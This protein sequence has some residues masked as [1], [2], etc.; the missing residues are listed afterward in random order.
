[1]RNSSSRMHRLGLIA[2][3]LLVIC[4]VMLSWPSHS[5]KA[6]FPTNWLTVW[7]LLGRSHT[8][9]T[10]DAIENVNKSLFGV[11]KMTD[12]MQKAS[13]EIIEA[14]VSVD[15]DQITSSKHFDGE[16]L[17]EGQNR[18]VALALNVKSALDNSDTTLAR[19]SLGQ[20]LHTLQDFYSH[21]NW[22][23]LGHTSPNV[24]LGVPGISLNRL[25]EAEATC[26]D[27]LIPCD[28]CSF[29]NLITYGLTSGY[30][31][32]EDRDKPNPL[33]CNHGGPF[34]TLLGAGGGINK[35]SVLCQFS[36]HYY[37]HYQAAS[38]ATSHTERFITNL[39]TLYGVSDEQ[40]RLL[41]GV[42]VTLAFAI[43]TTGSM[44]GVIAS[45]KR[46]AIQI[47]DERL[48]TNQEPTKYVLTPFNDPYVGPTVVTSSASEFKSAI[49][50]LFADGGDDCPEL[51]MQGMLQAI[52]ASD[53]GGDL[54]VFTDADPKDS[55]LTGNVTN[56]AKEKKIKVSSALFG[57]CGFGLN[58]GS[59]QGQST[60]A[61]VSLTN[62]AASYTRVANETGGQVFTLSPS[63]ATKITRL[64]DFVVRANVVDLLSIGDTL[65]G[66]P[67]TYQV[68]INTGVSRV[69]FSISGPSSILIK[70]PD[71]SDVLLTDSDISSVTVSG[72]QIVS[73]LSPVTGYW[74][75]VINGIGPFSVAVTAESDLSLSSFKFVKFGGRPGHEGYFPISGLPLLGEQAIA[76]AIMVGSF[77]SA[78]F[79]LR[80]KAG[81][82]IQ[83]LDLETGNADFTGEYYGALTLPGREFLVYVAGLDITGVPYQ[84]VLPYQFKPQSLK[85]TAPEG[86]QVRA[87][88]TINYTFQVQNL[89]ASGTFRLTAS[90]DRSFLQGITPSSVKLDTNQS[91]D[92]TVTLHLPL[93]TKTGLSSTLTV[94]AENTSDPS[95]NNFAVVVSSVSDK[96]LD[97]G[98]KFESS[99]T[100]VSLIDP[101]NC[102]G[103]GNLLTVNT[104]FT[105]TGIVA[106][107]DNSGNEFVANLPS[108]LA[109]IGGSC[110]V[111]GEGGVSKGSCV[112]TSTQITW[113]GSVEVNEKININYKVQINDAALDSSQFCITSVLSYDSDSNGVNDSTVNVSGCTAIT[114]PSVGP[115]LPYQSRS[116]AS[117]QKPGSV[118]IYNVYTSGTDP[119]RQNTLMS[120][121]NTNPG[122]TIGVHLFFVDG[123]S[124][125]VADVTIRLTP[126]QTTSFL[127]SDLDPGTTG[128]MI[129]V[130]TDLNGCPINFNYLIGDLYANF[131]SGHSVNLTAIAVSAIAGGSP[132]CNVNAVTATLNFDGVSYNQLPRAVAIDN[133]N[134]RA[135]G[136]QTMLILNRLGGNM[137][138][139][140]DTLGSIFG[141]LYDD[142]TASTSFTIPGGACQLTGILSN[143]FP[144]TAPRFDT[145]ISA[146]RVGWMKLWQ[147]NDLGISGA[148]INYQ[149]NGNSR[150]QGHNLHVLS[151]TTTVTMTIP[152]FPVR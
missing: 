139:G 78:Q 39:T 112:I 111:T 27:C 46:E 98:A 65:A 80:S 127:A 148:V 57:S 29:V 64:V 119:M 50:S 142:Q 105:N 23:E 143:S 13:D 120:I 104:E 42:G 113:N 18:L 150:L 91:I 89:G 99:Q 109:G 30:F 133:V 70:R 68:P 6:F 87:G 37:K 14:N 38:I 74:S 116:E 140:A 53:E 107:G 73:I 145:M 8:R 61:K 28:L 132:N 147:Q 103:R 69:V 136:N 114:C 101:L 102:T 100:K 118:L 43:D 71:G 137:L 82:L 108:Q 33:K 40:I 124:C 90:D 44:G 110:T 41:M 56:L 20:A 51:A 45:V 106:Q 144:R 3:S 31:G 77:T 10:R 152:V 66:T 7:G 130:A 63:E 95:I 115:G 86:Q 60:T 84:R 62:S 26:V 35:D 81:E 88:Q 49:D 94:I 76:D 122:L 1:M 123:S 67:K 138:S 128:Y 92:M 32:G 16:S 75:I 126:N 141:L 131:N 52:A 96:G 55:G 12:S 24:A 36:P 15:C 54:F 2:G 125:A 5:T 47:V 85:I 48:G 134:S 19:I 58:S 135:A 72:G 22:V 11:M 97:G 117:D 79:E 146:G 25:S 59:K 9:I 149:P 121:S 17:P 151:T 129:A 83:A 4:I 34:D 21:S 93:G